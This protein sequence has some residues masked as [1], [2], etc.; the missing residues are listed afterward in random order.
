MSEKSG[1]DSR[2]REFKFVPGLRSEYSGDI[3]AFVL[4]NHL[5]R[6]RA[7]SN[8]STRSSTSNHSTPKS[9]L[10]SGANSPSTKS[11]K[12]PGR[13]QNDDAAGAFDHEIELFAS[14]ELPLLPVTST[15]WIDPFQS[16]VL[17]SNEVTARLLRE[18]EIPFNCKY[19]CLC[20]DRCRYR[21]QN[22]QPPL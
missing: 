17:P 19:N 18:C 4:L 16:L 7:G 6:Q 20:V 21:G 5:A 1:S 3:R 13:D 8:A 10:T 22:V 14:N 11:E 15:S 12:E 2:R 9:Y